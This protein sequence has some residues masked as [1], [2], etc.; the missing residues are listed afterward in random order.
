MTQRDKTTLE[1]FEEKFL[2]GEIDQCWEW[3]AATN[4]S[5]YGTF[6]V[7]GVGVLAHRYAYET[8]VLKG[9]IPSG[10]CVLHSCDNPL[11]VN[12]ASHL[13]LGT[14][15][16]NNLERTSKGRQAF[17]ERNRHAK[18]NNGLVL[19]IRKLHLEGVTEAELARRFSVAPNTVNG[20]LN[21]KT[22][23]HI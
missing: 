15:R 12:Y 8:Y 10:L 11:C 16:E 18:L 19:E 7:K 1:R 21:R 2:K 20:I 22:W 3:T 17:G 6:G 14:R 5:G 4:A 9:P 13:R 23:K